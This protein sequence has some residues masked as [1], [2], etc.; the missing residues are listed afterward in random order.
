MGLLKTDSLA[1]GSSGATYNAILDQGCEFDGKLT[2]EG[3]VR[4]DG[5]F[6]GEIH[7]DSTLVVG[8]SGKVEATIKVRHVIISGEVNG[9]VEATEKV[10]ILAPGVLRGNIKTPN[11]LIEEGVI[12]D[13]SCN[14][15]GSTMSGRSPEKRKSG[16]EDEESSSDSHEAISA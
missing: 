9:T 3:T 2:F 10:E 12:F 11:L 15:A 7:S 8:E 14:M 16:K 4:I 1:I 5:L 6:R 13:G